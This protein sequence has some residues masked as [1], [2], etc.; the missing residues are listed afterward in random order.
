MFIRTERLF[1]RP[2]FPEDWR[3]IHHGMSDGSVPR[4]LASAPWPF[5]AADAIEYCARA[6]RRGPFSFSITL[7]GK[8]GAPVIG[9]LGMEPAADR[10]GNALELGYWIARDWRGRGYASEAVAGCLET[11]RA[12]GARRIVAGHF[13]DNPASGR[14]LD[15]AGFARTGELAPTPCLARGGMAVLA[16]RYL[17]DLQARGTDRATPAPAQVA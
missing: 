13:L 4:M 7:P 10:G 14:V 1:L 12:L 16:R 3:A 6:A 15:R 17:L 9:Q 2:V 8:A 5:T 11:A